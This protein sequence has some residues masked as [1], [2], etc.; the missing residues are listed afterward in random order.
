MTTNFET[1]QFA[2]DDDTGQQNFEEISVSNENDEPPVNNANP[3]V[4]GNSVPPA[5]AGAAPGSFGF[6]FLKKL[7]CL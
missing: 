5:V 4:N 1:E 3:N 6:V 2:E 7:L